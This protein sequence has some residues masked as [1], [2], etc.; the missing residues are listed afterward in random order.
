MAVTDQDHL[1]EAIDQRLAER[2]T[3]EYLEKH[4]LPPPPLP[5]PGS[6]QHQ[7][8]VADEA[9]RQERVAAAKQAEAEAIAGREAEAERQRAEWE[10]NAPRRE[11]AQRELAELDSEL[12]RLG[13]RRHAL[14]AEAS[15]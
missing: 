3:R 8:M 15:R 2:R 1:A 4:R 9:K 6:W 14:V 11:K 12:A 5:Q 10:A 7:I 13:R